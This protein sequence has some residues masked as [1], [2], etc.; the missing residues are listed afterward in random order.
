M[1]TP[2][3]LHN[4]QREAVHKVLDHEHAML[5][6]DMGLGKTI[7]CL[8]A[9]VSWVNRG[10]TSGVLVVAPKRIC[11]SVWRQEAQQWTHTKGLKFSSML[12]NEAARQRGLFTRSHIYL[13]NYDN[14]EWLHDEILSRFVNRG[15]PLPFDT[16]IYDEVSR[17]KNARIRQGTNRGRA[18]VK[19]LPYFRRRVGLTGTPASNGLLDLF[20][21]FLVVDG[22]DRLGVS[23]D[24]YK[25]RY[26]RQADFNGYRFEPM[27]GSQSAIRDAVSDIT[28]SMRNDDYLELPPYIFQ[29][30]LVDLPP[31]ARKAYDAMEKSMMLEFETG[32]ELDIFNAASLTN[33]CLQ[34]AN[35]AC[36]L[37]PSEPEWE[38]F[39]KVKL[40]ALEEVIE[41]SAGKPVLVLYQFQ[42]DAQRIMKT[43]K[44]ARRIASCTP[45]DEFNDIVR[46]W[47][48]GELPILIGHPASIGHGLNIQEGGNTIVWFG[49]TWSLDHYDQANARL[50][51]QGQT[52][53]VVVHR[54]LAKDTLDSA[55][56]DAL[57][58]KASDETGI[59]NAIER[60]KALENRAG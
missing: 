22:G 56:S 12:G 46:Q 38:A 25:R 20:G 51:R 39:H 42:H 58:R 52:Q 32:H 28:L 13:I 15:V 21:Q 16:V 34:I 60:Y 19:L 57:Q 27:P 26:F 24:A 14:L 43:F 59:R 36:Y 44:Q 18:M 35:G 5:W 33:R 29:D 49:L 48:R 37:N 54:I 7:V 1:L 4:Y 45:E 53:P 9:V 40:G 11:Q 55:V 31:K 17:L 3:D 23:H 47:N 50:R 30:I 10:M 41:E 2:D 8:T 6:M